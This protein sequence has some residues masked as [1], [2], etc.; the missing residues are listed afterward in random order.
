[1][2]TISAMLEVDLATGQPAGPTLPG[3]VGFLAIPAAVLILSAVVGTLAKIPTQ[4][5][6]ALQHFAGGVV[7]SAVASELVPELKSE[8]APIWAIVIGFSLGVA[9]LLLIRKLFPEAEDDDTE[10][11]FNNMSGG[12]GEIPWGTIIPILID[13]SCDG[14]LVG[15]SFAA[16]SGA[17]FILAISIALEMAS[18]GAAT[19]VAM[20]KK[21]VD[22]AVSMVVVTFLA[23]AIVLSGALA[24]LGASSIAGTAGYYALLAFGVAA[25]LWLAT[26]DLLLE[27]HEGADGEKWWITSMFFAGFLVPILLD[28]LGE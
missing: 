26:E 6:K 3:V 7:I 12:G 8:M 5:E 2:T 10:G 24:F 4:V 11:S 9:M 25:C 22:T 21:G 27:A 20:K 19:L 13:L 14:M 18:L 17:G 15:L 28:K 23:G 16:G 1:M